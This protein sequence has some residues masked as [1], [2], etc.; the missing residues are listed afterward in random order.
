[1]AIP[2]ASGARCRVFVSQLAVVPLLN[3]RNLASESW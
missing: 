2:G 3:G 1:M